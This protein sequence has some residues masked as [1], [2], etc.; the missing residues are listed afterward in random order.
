MPNISQYIESL[1]QSTPFNVY[2][3][4]ISIVILCTIISS[5]VKGFQYAVKTLPYYLLFFYA[6]IVICSTLI[7]RNG[8]GGRGVHLIPFWS[9]FA[10]D[11]FPRLPIENVMNFLAFMPMGFLLGLITIKLKWYQ[12]ATVG[13]G[14]SLFVELTQLIFKRGMCELDDVIHNTLGCLVG[15][16]IVGLIGFIFKKRSY[17]RTVQYLYKGKSMKKTLILVL[18]FV[19]NSI[20]VKGQ[21]S[22]CV[23]NTNKEI[24]SWGN[25]KKVLCDVPYLAQG[26]LEDNNTT[27]VINREYTLI[28]DILIPEGCSLKFTGGSFR[29]KH[30]VTGCNTIIVADKE[31]IFSSDII[32]GGTWNVSEVY[33]EWF[34]AKGDGVCDDAFAIN[35]CFSFSSVD[36]PVR[37]LFTKPKYTVGEIINF[38]GKN[39]L[40][41]EGTNK[42]VIKKIKGNL[43]NMF[44]GGGCRHITIRNL[45]FDGSLDDWNVEIPTKPNWSQRTYNACIVAASSTADIMLDNC[46]IKNF[47]YGVF[48]GGASEHY[49]LINGF[50]YTDHISITNCI[51][52]GNK[53]GCIDT[54]NRYG[55]FI[56]NNFFNDNGNIAVHIEPTMINDLSSAYNTSDVNTARY[57]I[58][59]V[60]I[61][62]NTFVWSEKKGIGIKIY[63]GAYAVNITNNHFVN[64]IAAIHSEGTKMFSFS[65]N[66]V[67]NGIGIR[68]YGS[69]GTGSIYGN[70]LLN[71]ES[72]ISCYND[73]K[74]MGGIDIHDN[75]I[76]LS[77]SISSHPD[78][79]NVQNSK[80]H[81]N[82][83]RGYFNNKVWKLRGVLDISGASN[84]EI[85][86]NK[87]LKCNESTIPFFLVPITSQEE[88]S[89]FIKKGVR[90]FNNVYEQKLDYEFTTD[91][92]EERP[93][94][95][96]VGQQFY[97]LKLNKLIIYKGKKWVDSNGNDIE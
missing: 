36:H 14:F 39:N 55:L 92:A 25:N 80:Y 11:N 65:N 70:I 10:T 6:A 74:T 26:M 41:L 13:C 64:G 12:V 7:F 42:N 43:N 29:G 18:I 61:C 33:P 52:E 45:I 22:P 93:N 21:A 31:E 35:R 50:N 9:Y 27:Y 32:I 24:M 96:Y 20:V 2:I 71:V 85:Y 17:W 94:N 87:L 97:D 67:K 91:A 58:D 56:N 23:S 48:L 53:T 54:Y 89:S 88:L 63:K 60:N 49:K 44:E 19:L 47:Y 72:G 5:K 30:T 46:V 90:I 57:P 73:A 78:L 28:E 4:L 86:N 82:I 66:K 79:F 51:F 3:I 62:N 1:L 37:V 81:D 68:L 34:G 38:S 76:I 16:S 59:G 84:C 77:D 75:I 69:V 8:E 83:I 95:P 40:S 15:Y